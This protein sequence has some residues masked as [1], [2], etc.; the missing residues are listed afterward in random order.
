MPACMNRTEKMK[1][2]K[3]KSS[4]AQAKDTVMET[5]DIHILR[6]SRK[7]LTIRTMRRTRP[8]LKMRRRRMYALLSPFRTSVPGEKKSTKEIIT[9]ATSKRF[10]C[11]SSL[12]MNDARRAT[13]RMMISRVKK[14][15][16]PKLAM[17]KKI[18]FSSSGFSN[19]FRMLSSTSMPIRNVF[20]RIAMETIRKKLLLN[21]KRAKQESPDSARRASFAASWTAT[22]CSIQDS[23]SILCF[24]APSRRLRVDESPF[25]AA[26]FR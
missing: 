11:Q 14:M 9:R 12:N 19:A 25:S 3:I 1:H 21:T 26:G 8:T 17:K 24:S 13:M 6:N 10:Q 22:C 2:I 5:I 20:A 4:S 16:K 15:V 23:Q 18:G 7:N